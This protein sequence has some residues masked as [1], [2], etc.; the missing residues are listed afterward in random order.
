MN[1]NGATGILEELQ[2]QNKLIRE[3]NR[4]LLQLIETLRWLK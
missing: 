2:E 4:I 1:K 3:Q